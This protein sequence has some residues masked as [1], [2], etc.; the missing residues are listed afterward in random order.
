[1][2]DH[3]TCHPSHPPVPGLASRGRRAVAEGGRCGDRPHWLFRPLFRFQGARAQRTGRGEPATGV[4]GQNSMLRSARSVRSPDLSTGRSC[5]GTPDGPGTTAP[6]RRGP[7]LRSTPWRG[8]VRGASRTGFP[9]P[10]PEGDG[11]RS[12][13]EP[14]RSGRPPRNSA[15]G[16]PAAGSSGEGDCSGPLLCV[17]PRWARTRS[18]RPAPAPRV[19]DPPEQDALLLPP[20]HHRPPA[21]GEVRRSQHATLGH[22]FVVEAQPALGDESPTL[23]P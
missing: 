8:R 6:G 17:S 12:G 16:P 9:R 19:S 18:H 5:G 21:V 1:M 4:V 23:A 10:T 13:L 2:N 11:R 22:R 20:T 7:R 15:S 3:G 14:Y